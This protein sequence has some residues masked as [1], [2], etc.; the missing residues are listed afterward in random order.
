MNV[1][2]PGGKIRLDDWVQ[3]PGNWPV[4]NDETPLEPAKAVSVVH[5]PIENERRAKVRQ[6]CLRIG[7]VIVEDNRATYA[8]VLCDLSE[9]GARIKIRADIDLPEHIRVYDLKQVSMTPARIVWRKDDLM[10]V[11]WTGPHVPVSGATAATL[12]GDATR[13][14]KLTD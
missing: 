7:K 13:R 14:R 3:G 2:K 10:G 9:D 12:N 4:M 11:A 1:R 6:P 5:H 8:C